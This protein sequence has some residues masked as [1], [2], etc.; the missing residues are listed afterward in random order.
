[1]TK[2]AGENR[3]RVSKHRISTISCGII[4]DLD[5]CDRQPQ[6][7]PARESTLDAF[8]K[9]AIYP[10]KPSTDLES[11]PQAIWKQVRKRKRS[12]PSVVS[13]QPASHLTTHRDR[14]LLNRLLVARANVL[15]LAHNIQTLD[16]FAENGVFAVQVRC[17]SGQDEELTAVGVGT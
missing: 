14:N 15:N 9:K 16:H 8:Q 4:P 2:Q 17:G 1:V 13:N 6:R 5:P 12:G 10:C 3:Q 7:F 11:P